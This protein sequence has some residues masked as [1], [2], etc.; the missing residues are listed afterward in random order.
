MCDT[1]CALPPV[2]RDHSVIL[3]KSSDCEV[4]EAQYIYRIPAQNHGPGDVFRAAHIVIPQVAQTYDAVISRSFWTWGGELGINEHGLAVGNEAVY[5]NVVPECDGLVV[6]DMLRLALERASTAREAI[7][8]IG[9]L[10]RQYGQGGTA[11]CGVI[12]ISMAATFWLTGVKRGCW[13]LPGGNGLL[14]ALLNSTQSRT[15]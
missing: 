10:V 15:P 2:T 14:G 13:K 9:S 6:T 3:A 12:H 5:S 1:F 8:V 11:S 7:D 4:N